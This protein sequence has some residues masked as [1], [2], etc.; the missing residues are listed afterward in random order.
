MKPGP[1]IQAGVPPK[2]AALYKEAVPS[3]EAATTLSTS[4]T[5]IL[6]VTSQRISESSESEEFVSNSSSILNLSDRLSSESIPE[7]QSTLTS[8]Q[9]RLQ[10]QLHHLKTLGDFITEDPPEPINSQLEQLRCALLVAQTRSREC[11]NKLRENEKEYNQLRSR[12]DTLEQR[13]ASSKYTKSLSSSF[14]TFTRT[15]TLSPTLYTFSLAFMLHRGMEY[16]QGMES[17]ILHG[18]R[19]LFTRARSFITS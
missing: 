7:C 12:V 2:E 5:K 8:L 16:V 11:T 1:F 4:R 13:N 15:R 17:H 18:G 6:A 9:T 19:F 14:Y 3:S 10:T